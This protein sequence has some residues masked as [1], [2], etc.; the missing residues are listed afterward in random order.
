MV[1]LKVHMYV[2]D[3]QSTYEFPSC[4]L[5]YLKLSYSVPIKFSLRVCTCTQSSINYLILI[6]LRVSEFLHCMYLQGK[7]DLIDS[8]FV[9][10]LFLCSTSQNQ[11]KSDLGIFLEHAPDEMLLFFTLP[12]ACV[13]S[14][15]THLAGPLPGKEQF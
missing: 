8:S 10:N 9:L 3:V 11:Y 2:V 12:S 15:A 5:F 1:E 14:L 4:V 7:V 6:G 13:L